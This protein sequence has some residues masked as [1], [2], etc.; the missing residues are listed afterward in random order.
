LNLI[1]A[2]PTWLIALFGLALVAAAIEDA[3]RLRISNVTSL[4]VV[5]GAV[6]AAVIEGPS[7]VLWQNVAV[8]IAILLLGTA[9]F[10][11]GWLGGGDV[12]LFAAAGLWFDLRSAIWFVALTF[13]AGGV[14][15]LG[16][17][18][19]RPFRRGAKNSRN[20]RVP[21]GIAIALG[22]LAM[23]FI[24]RGAPRYHE[25]PLPPIKINPTHL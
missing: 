2:A 10:S 7:L 12:K 22:A 13:L 25:R 15:A 23:V 5:V 16:Y 24:D 4:L 17:L 18:V 14:V 11:A 8:L 6:A 1:A 3:L 19:S 20:T 9:A 21:Y